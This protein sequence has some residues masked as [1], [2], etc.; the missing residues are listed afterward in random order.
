[1]IK[2]GIIGITG[3]M[4]TALLGHL[5]HAS[6][7]SLEKVFLRFPNA[8]I[9]GLPA[10][11]RR[12]TDLVSFL[13]DLDVVIDFSCPQMSLSLLEAARVHPT[14]IVI[15][16]TGHEP[17]FYERVREMSQRQPLLIAAN[18]S[19][20]IAIFEMILKKAAHAL[21]SYDI[22]LHEAHHIH[23]EDAPSGTAK[24]LLSIIKSALP[25]DK[26]IHVTSTRAGGILGDHEV[27]FIG[28]DEILTL[29]HRCINRD[30]FAKGAL[31]A[32]A[33]LAYRSPG[34][35]SMH[36]VLDIPL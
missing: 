32:A 10:H 33:F 5:I 4:G 11:T 25:Q 21:K 34:L 16:T 14:P 23:K 29:S 6:H 17:S 12:E 18:T 1:M 30:L 28:E 27:S 7:F 31:H 3:R 15:C 26:D 9:D 8:V 13:A 36:D 19:L 22:T 24:E 2:L 20:G 35:Y